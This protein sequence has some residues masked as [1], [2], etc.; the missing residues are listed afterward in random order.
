MKNCSESVNCLDTMFIVTMLIL[1]CLG[2]SDLLPTFNSTVIIVF[3]AVDFQ[4][5]FVYFKCKFLI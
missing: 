3:L 4:E 5:F 2:V 1:R